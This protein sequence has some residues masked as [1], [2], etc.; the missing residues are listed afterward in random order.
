MFW[1]RKKSIIDVEK[2]ARDLYDDRVLVITT[3][4][5]LLKEHWLTLSIRHSQT[6]G[7]DGYNNYRIDGWIKELTYF[8]DNV[9]IS[10]LEK[11]LAE[12]AT[13]KRLGKILLVIF[14]GSVNDLPKDG[15]SFET[16]SM[17][18]ASVFMERPEITDMNTIAT[19]QWAKLKLNET[20]LDIAYNDILSLPISSLGVGVSDSR[21][22]FDLGQLDLLTNLIYLLISWLY[23]LRE[24]TSSSHG[25]ESIPTD[26]YD[27]E[28]YVAKKLIKM[29]FTA[30]TTRRSGDYGVDVLAEKNSKSYAIQCKYYTKPV[31]IHAVQEIHAGQVFYKANYSAVISNSTFTPAAKRL[32]ATLGILLLNDRKLD[33]LE[34]LNK[35]DT[36]A[37]TT[38]KKQ[39]SEQL[40]ES[41]DIRQ[42]QEDTDE[43]I[44]VILPTIRN[45]NT[46]KKL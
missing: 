35:F 10:K 38:P 34:I 7:N 31:G 6:V 3:L 36:R 32:S 21:V 22:K 17:K 46:N 4:I 1:Q 11:F 19:K 26:P 20:A 45:D 42:N 30:K 27:Y 29:G 25:S 2:E 24:D 13:T 12:K 33:S 39:S 16:E 15:L 23:K 37:R 8:R 41:A 9:V 43:L 40:A 18:L 14:A 28:S 5:D 44:T